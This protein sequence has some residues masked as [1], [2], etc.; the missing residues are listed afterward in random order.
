MRAGLAVPL[1]LHGGPRIGGFNVGLEGRK[2]ELRGIVRG[3]GAEIRLGLLHTHQAILRARRPAVKALSPREHR[4]TLLARGSQTKQIAAALGIAYST[5]E[6]HLR[7]ARHRLGAITREQAVA[8]AVA[9][10]LIE[11]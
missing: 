8:L 5:A 11:P 9:Q 7:N 6:L 2:K 10:H 1:E 4:L 3:H